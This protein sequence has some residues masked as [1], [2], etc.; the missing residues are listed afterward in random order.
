M[1][2]F[3]VKLAEQQ[4]AV[5]YAACGDCCMR[6]A[7]HCIALLKVCKA[8]AQLHHLYTSYCDAQ[9]LVLACFVLQLWPATY[10]QAGHLCRLWT[11]RK[12]CK[13]KTPQWFPCM[14]LSQLNRSV[15][16][17]AVENLTDKDRQGRTSQCLP[18]MT[19]STDPPCPLQLST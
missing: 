6:I 9:T 4:G 8:A 7:L 1:Y 16:P 18:C 13:A 14:T 3:D 2:C 10:K 17:I 5:M 19:L 11:S 12:T 15:L